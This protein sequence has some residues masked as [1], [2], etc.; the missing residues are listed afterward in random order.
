VFFVFATEEENGGE[1]RV[2]SGSTGAHLGWLGDD[3][4][5]AFGCGGSEELGDAAGEVNVNAA[6]SWRAPSPPDAPVTAAMA[7][8]TRRPRARKR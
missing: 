5:A 8:A 7:S 3:L 6:R 2:W 4:E 1:A